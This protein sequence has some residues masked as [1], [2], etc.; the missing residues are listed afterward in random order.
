MSNSLRPH[1]LQPARFLCPWN[2]PD[3]NTGMGC[4]F[5]L[6][7]IF[8]TQGLNP[9][10]LRLLH[11]Q[12]DSLPLSHP[13]SPIFGRQSQQNLLTMWIVRHRT[14]DDPEAFG[15]KVLEGWSCIQLTDKT[16]LWSKQVLVGVVSGVPF[17]AC[18]HL[19]MNPNGDALTSWQSEVHIWKSSL[20]WRVV[21]WWG[22]CRSSL[23]R[24]LTFPV[25]QKYGLQQRGSCWKLEKK[26]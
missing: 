4:H 26:V 11:W 22:V 21:M 3:K 15:L 6:Q 7:G 13:G 12:T 10:F 16:N 5:L 14:L 8:P 1:G 25:K 17:C 9:R 2:F 18:Y 23:L 24:A 19:T 20:C